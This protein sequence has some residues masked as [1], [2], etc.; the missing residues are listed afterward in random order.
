M[1]AAGGESSIDAATRAKMASAADALGTARLPPLANR[2]V[3]ADS[4]WARRLGITPDDPVPWSF[5]R[6][7]TTLY[8][9]AS[10]VAHPSWTGTRMVIKRSE[11]S[12]VIDTEAAGRGTEALQ[13]VPALLGLALLISAHAFREP[14]PETIAKFA[15]WLADAWN[16]R[17]EA[18]PSARRTS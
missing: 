18:L 5:R 4:E 14:D 3:T 11:A 16:S 15:E 6:N 9:P 13:P 12:V 8:R 2:A 1:V 17:T 7:Y 10:A